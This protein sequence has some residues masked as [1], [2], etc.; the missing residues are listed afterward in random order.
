MS[1]NEDTK[2]IRRPKRRLHFLLG[3]MLGAGLGLASGA[4]LF[5]PSCN[6]PSEPP[7]PN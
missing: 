2:R 4:G 5:H 3:L 1:E 6:D 7:T